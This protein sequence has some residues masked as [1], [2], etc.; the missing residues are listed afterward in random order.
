MTPVGPT[1]T[2]PRGRRPAA[3]RTASPRPAAPRRGGVARAPRRAPARPRA[4]DRPLPSRPRVLGRPGRPRPRLVL[5][6]LVILL[7][8]GA[9]AFRLVEV[10][11][12]G[13]EEYTSFGIQQR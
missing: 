3:P 6:L 8:F 11:A 10:Q 5:A 13:G 7:G 9:I 1:R 4:Y 12:V 2:P